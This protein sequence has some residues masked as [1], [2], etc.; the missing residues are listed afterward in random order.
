MRRTE[1]EALVAKGCGVKKVI[2]GRM[3]L[4]HHYDAERNDG[5]ER[6]KFMQERKAIV[7]EAMS[8]RRDGFTGIAVGLRGTNM[9]S[10]LEGMAEYV[11]T[12]VGR[13]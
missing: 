1:N 11:D 3:E 8:L 12:G 10:T 2:Y 6:N 4:R 5:A 13:R 7:T 9:P